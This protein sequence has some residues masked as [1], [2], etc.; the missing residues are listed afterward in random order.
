[1][2]HFDL[3]IIGSGSGNSLIDEQFAG[4]KIALVDKGTFGGTCLNVGCIPTKMFVLP[5]DHAASPHEAK[6]LGV[7]LSYEGADWRGI[8]NRIFGRIDPISDGGKHWRLENEN[9]TLF[10]ESAKFTGPK[11]LQVGDQEITADRFVIAAGSRAMVPGIPGLIGPGSP[12]PE[13]RK[14]RPARGVHTSDTVMRID[15]LPQT[16]AIMGGGFVAAEFAHVFASLGVDVTIIARS[17]PLLRQEDG[18]IA[19]RF[20]EQISKRTRVL[21]DVDVREVTMLE[22]DRVRLTLS[23]GGPVE[24]DLLLVATGRTPNGDTLNLEATGLGLNNAGYLEVD[25]Y[26]RTAVEGIFAMGDV[27][28]PYQLKHV[29]NQEMR[30]VQHNLLH[31]DELR[32]S[33]HRFVP[34]AVFSEPQIGAVGLTEEQAKKQGVSYVSVVQEYG[35]VAYGWALEDESNC[36]KVLADPQT[37]KLLGAHCIGPQAATI[38][39]PLIQAMS[40]GTAAHQMAR[41]QY[42]IHPALTEVIENALLGLPLDEGARS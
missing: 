6:R 38:I 1:M 31:P 8:R 12:Q 37:G 42:W 35:S 20:T 5:A 33:D 29:A 40:F 34:H 28:S 24:A 17:G 22:S 21:C 15:E 18:E 3:C 13:A 11:T 36:L 39:Q 7:E 23:E 14:T 27:S 4:Q 30:V 16:M 19:R 2:S 10:V 25:E 41:G 9:V 32:L 26:Q